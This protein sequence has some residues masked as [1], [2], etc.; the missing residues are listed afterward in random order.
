MGKRAKENLSMKIEKQLFKHRDEEE[1]ADSS[2]RV[3]ATGAKVKIRDM[4]PAIFKH[5]DLAFAVSDLANSIQ[6]KSL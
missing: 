5:Q 2:T 1:K 6:M 3:R 4:M